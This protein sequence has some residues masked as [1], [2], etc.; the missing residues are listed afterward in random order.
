MSVQE[1]MPVRRR[2]RRGSAAVAEQIRLRGENLR[3]RDKNRLDELAGQNPRPE[4][5]LSKVGNVTLGKIVLHRKGEH[6]P[7][8]FGVYWRGITGQVW[9]APLPFRLQDYGGPGDIKGNNQRWVEHKT[10]KDAKGRPRKRLLEFGDTAAPNQRRL[11]KA[12][13]A[14]YDHHDMQ[15]EIII[16]IPARRYFWDE[17]QERWVPGREE[18]PPKGGV[19]IVIS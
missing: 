10:E 12:G 5:A 8:D 1:V 13:K 7:T 2:V 9:D 4:P 17:A 11:T 16:E 14:F 3:S 19:P 6:T 18:E 15:K